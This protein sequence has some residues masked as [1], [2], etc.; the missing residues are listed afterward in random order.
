[1]R[2]FRVLVCGI[3]LV[4]ALAPL[5]A[6]ADEDSDHDQAE[7]VNA[8]AQLQVAQQQADAFVDQAAL[9]AQNERE[10]AFATSESLRERQLHNAANARTLEQIASTLAAVARGEGDANA[11]N[12]LAILQIKANALVVRADGNVANALAIGR[13]DEIANARAQ[14]AALHELAD[15]MT[16]TL[17]Q[18]YMQNDRV[19]ADDEAAALQ[20]SAATE[21]DNEQAMGDDDVFA[22]DTIL[23]AGDLAADSATIGGESDGLPGLQHAEASLANAEAMAADDTP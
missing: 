21:A 8:E 7:V 6:F 20:A 17:A 15:Y 18:Q 16:G 2:Q 5:G 13:A 19:I 22:A 11:R 9:A 23:D 1:M 14:S 3:G 10:I 4:L 12:D